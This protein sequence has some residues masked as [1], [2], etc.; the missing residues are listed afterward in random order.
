[1]FSS[2]N[3]NKIGYF[4]IYQCHTIEKGMSHFK[5]RPFGQKKISSIT[6][7]YLS[8]FNNE[9]NAPLFYI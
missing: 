7:L 2:E 9:I 5:L 6:F 4:I 3:T 1:M 8:I